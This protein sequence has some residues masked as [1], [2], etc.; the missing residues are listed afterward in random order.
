MKETRVQEGTAP[1]AVRRSNREKPESLSK[2]KIIR[3][4]VADDVP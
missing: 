4:D 2:S 3:G 1:K